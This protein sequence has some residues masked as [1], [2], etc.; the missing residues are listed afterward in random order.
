M[1][2]ILVLTHNF[3]V[4][5]V[6]LGF[7]S[8]T[9]GAIGRGKLYFQEARPRW[10]LLLRIHGLWSKNKRLWWWASFGQWPLALIGSSYLKVGAHGRIT[11]MFSWKLKAIK[12]HCFAKVLECLWRGICRSLCSR[13]E[14]SDIQITNGE[15]ARRSK[16]FSVTI[17][18]LRHRRLRAF[19]SGF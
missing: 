9:S 13:M 2:I 10:K 11:L 6:G 16:V 5:Q 1:E 7:W 17:H 14:F 15:N 4:G 19:L 3:R 12:R 8:E 18:G